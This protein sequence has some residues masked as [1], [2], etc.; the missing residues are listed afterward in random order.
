MFSV[1]SENNKKHQE[2]EEK[3]REKDKIELEVSDLEKK[4]IEYKFQLQRAETGHTVDV[5]DITKYVTPQAKL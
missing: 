3:H 2:L 4:T 5:P 1:E